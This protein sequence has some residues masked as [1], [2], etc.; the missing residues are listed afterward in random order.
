M[1]KLPA[2]LFALL[3]SAPACAAGLPQFDVEKYCQGAANCVETEN[4]AKAEITGLEVE[5]KIMAL[6]AKMGKVLG[7]SYS[8]VHHCIETE[9][10]AKASL[11]KK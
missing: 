7:G 9:L 1:K 11:G 8:M 10:E 6:C 3:L 5:P 4:K 2:V